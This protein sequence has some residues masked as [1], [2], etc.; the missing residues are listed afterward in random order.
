M[1]SLNHK[2][3]HAKHCN[4]SRDPFTRALAQ[5]ELLHDQSRALV[6]LPPVDLCGHLVLP[7]PVEPWLPT[8][9][10]GAKSRRVSTHHQGSN[11]PIATARVSVAI[12]ST[13][14]DDMQMRDAGAGAHSSLSSTRNRQKM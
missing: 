2:S 3:S 1:P 5:T 10:T 7:P 11:P 12:G 8:E 14:H 9:E 4:V 13:A 6:L